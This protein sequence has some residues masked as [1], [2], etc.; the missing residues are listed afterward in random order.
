MKL[1]VKMSQAE[2]SRTAARGWVTRA[3]K[4]LETLCSKPVESI[5]RILLTDGIDEFDKRLENLDAAQNAVE[6]ELELTAIDQEIENA[7]DFRE[8]AR[9]PRIKAAKILTL[10]DA[11][12]NK[13]VAGDQSDFGSKSSVD[14]MAKLPKLELPKFSGDVIEWQS[15]WDKFTAIVD[16]SELPTISKFTY[17]QSLLE[18]EA[19]SA[20]QGLST[21]ATNYKIAC[22]ILVDRFGRTERIIFAHIQ[23]LLN[24]SVPASTTKSKVATLWKLKDNLQAH[25]RSLETL[26]VNG[27]QYGVILTPLILSRL[28]QDI[29]LEWA[30]ESKDKESDLDWLMN[31][32]QTEIERRERSQTFKDSVPIKS[33][34]KRDKATVSALQTSSETNGCGFCGK[35]HLTERCWDMLKLAIPE[36]KEKIKSSGLCFRCLLKGH[37]AKG[38]A[39]KCLKCKGR[40]NQIICSGPNQGSIQPGSSYDSKCDV[41]NS[42]PKLSTTSGGGD[43]PV[44]SGSIGSSLSH[45]GMS[46][47]SFKSVN[48]SHVILQIAQAYVINDGNVTNATVLFDTGSDRSYISRSLVRKVGPKWVGA[49]QISYAAFGNDKPGKSHLR[50]IYE[51]NLKG[52]QTENEPLPICVTEV[53]SICSP[54]Y[55]PKIPTETLKSLGPLHFANKYEEDKK[56]CIDILIGLDN[57]WKFFRSG[58]VVLP[59]GLVAQESVLGWIVSGSWS[60]SPSVSP[61]LVSTHQLVCFSDVSEMSLRH[62]WDLESIGISDKEVSVFDPVLDEFHKNVRFYDKRYEVAL[63]WKKGLESKRLLNNEKLARIRLETLSR[64]LEKDPVL[65]EQ[66]NK[67]L[68]EMEQNGVIEE[69][70]TD[71]MASM[72]PIYYMPHRPVVRESSTTTRVRPVF[73]ASAPGYNGVSLNDCLETGP[74]L[75]PNLAEMLIRFRRW[76]VAL[77][78]DIT[79]ASA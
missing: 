16:G 2:K 59:G 74:S 76:K 47:T 14:Q 45:V 35:R 67:A 71:E 66:Y 4:S 39:A 8:K 22:D 42:T 41:D 63:P 79:K 3:S 73:D 12:S 25:V 46:S 70:P 40:H 61:N 38:C 23:D 77:T 72:Y 37:I 11:D 64:K 53:P 9:I 33:E 62:F 1:N 27:T 68:Q 54:L 15:F 29:R 48:E 13:A 28:P 78:A 17:L 56:I 34:E 18:G 7:A 58:V 49:Q 6:L 44:N 10:L 57:Y 30:R 55:S 32:L 51:I 5:D 52:L 26:G 20:I 31:F 75:I 69:V 50:N 43:R 21:T 24:I 19:K 60:N 36:R 65:E